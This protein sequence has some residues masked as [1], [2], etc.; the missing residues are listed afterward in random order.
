MA[1]PFSNQRCFGSKR[2]E[3]GYTNEDT[4]RRMSDGTELVKSA[5]IPDLI[6][7]DF[8]SGFQIEDLSVCLETEGFV[9]LR[10]FV[11]RDAVTNLLALVERDVKLTLV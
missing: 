9:V 3:N 1:T 6:R 10:N 7:T 4:K 8:Y 5:P 11:P 2:K